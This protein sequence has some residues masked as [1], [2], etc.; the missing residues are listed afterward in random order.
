MLDG[1]TKIGKQYNQTMDSLDKAGKYLKYGSEALD[2]ISR[3]SADYS[4]GL[5]YLESLKSNY[6][7]NPK[8]QQA[9][10]EIEELYNKEFEAW[11][12]DF[13][14]NAEELG[15][16]YVKGAV[17]KANP[18]GA[19]LSGIEMGLDLGGEITGL[20]TQA[21]ETYNA[22]TCYNLNTDLDVAY[23]NAIEKFSNADPSAENYEA[24]AEDVRNCFELRKK[25]TIDMFKHMAEASSGDKKS[26]YKYCQMEAE[27][28]TMRDQTTPKL[29]SYDEYLKVYGSGGGGG[30]RF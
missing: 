23:K 25:N 15:I 30:H 28:V 14:K 18:V 1:R 8:L 26:Y 22:L 6:E 21:K 13:V 3:V 17:A 16:D 2:Y 29:I 12:V 9:L 27:K 10:E 4:K 7:G 24:L 11:A 5:A 20:G 19:V